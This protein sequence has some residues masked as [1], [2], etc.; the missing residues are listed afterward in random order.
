[1]RKGKI[2][3]IIFIIVFLLA[4]L[5]AGYNGFVASQL[6]ADFLSAILAVILYRKNH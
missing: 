6:I 2:K 3:A 4:A 5:M 1:M